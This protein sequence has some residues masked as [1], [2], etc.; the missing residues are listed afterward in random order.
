[1]VIDMGIIGSSVVQIHICFVNPLI[2]W[3]QVMAKGLNV[4][5]NIDLCNFV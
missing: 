3:N 5:D 2:Y 1:M 4:G